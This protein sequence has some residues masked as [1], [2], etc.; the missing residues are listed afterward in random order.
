MIRKYTV[1]HK[2][3]KSG[4]FIDNK[5]IAPWTID[6]FIRETIRRNNWKESQIEIQDSCI[7]NK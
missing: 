2:N 4:H 3:K 6:T 5:K 1:T 7:I